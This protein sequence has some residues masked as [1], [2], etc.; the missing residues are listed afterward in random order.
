RLLEAL[1]NQPQASSRDG[2]CRHGSVLN[3]VDGLRS[4]VTCVRPELSHSVCNEP[5]PQRRCADCRFGPRLQKVEPV[6]DLEAFRFK[7]GRTGRSCLRLGP[8]D[9]IPFLYD[10]LYA[11]AYYVTRVK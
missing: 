5:S 1:R 2:T 11:R 9:M 4:V 8:I 10:S 6:S 7:S 3:S